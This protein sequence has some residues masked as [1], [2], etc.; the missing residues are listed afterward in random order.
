MLARLYAYLLI[1]FVNE[2]PQDRWLAKSTDL[3]DLER[4]Q[5]M[6]QRGEVHF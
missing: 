6:I 5:R 2:T 3:A 1:P 4:R